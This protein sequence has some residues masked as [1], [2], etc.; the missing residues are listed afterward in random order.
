[1]YDVSKDVPDSQP[2]LDP[3]RSYSTLCE[4]PL[5]ADL[6]VNHLHYMHENLYNL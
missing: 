4:K 3:L 1:M 6:L 5:L 2:A